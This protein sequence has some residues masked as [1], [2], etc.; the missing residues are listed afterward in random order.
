MSEKP[1]NKTIF[2][3]REP[4]IMAENWLAMV[5]WYII[6]SKGWDCRCKG[7]GRKDWR[8]QRQYVQYGSMTRIA[9]A[10]AN[11]ALCIRT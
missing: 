7:D 1:P 2:G 9:D 5:D 4:V 8:P 6:G 11:L 3:P 10:G